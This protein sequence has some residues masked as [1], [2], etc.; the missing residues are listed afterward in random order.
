M[1]V[2]LGAVFVLFLAFTAKY[3]VS[4]PDEGYYYT[5][6]HRLLLGEKMIAD[7]W[8]L[9][10]LVHLFNLLPNILYIKLT[11]GTAGLILFMRYLFIAVDAAFYAYVYC[12]LRCFK[13]WGVAAA[14]LFCA[15]I[16][17]TLLTIAYFTAAPMATLAV[18]LMLVS[19]EK[20]KSAVKLVFAGIVMACGILAEP[21]LIAIFLMWFVLTAVREILKAKQK[22]F[23]E[24][25]A[26][27]LDKRIFTWT[28]L[29]AV[30][31]FIPYM[32]YLVL[33]GSFEGVGAAIPYLSS[34]EEYNGA[35]LIDFEKLW[36]A[37]N[38]YGIP[39]VLGGAVTLAAAGVLRIKKGLGPKRKQALLIAAFAF[40]A[41]GC[42][43]AA[44]TT[45][46]GKDPER[47]VAFLQYNNFTLLIFSPVLWL[48]CEK[49]TPRLFVLWL[50]GMLFSVL[51]DISSTVILASGGGLVRTACILQLPVLLGEL[52][53]PDAEK[54]KKAVRELREKAL[55]TAKSAVAVCVAAALL[56]NV[57]YILFEGVRK[58][59]EFL[60]SDAPLNS[61]IEKGPF[62]GLYTTAEIKGVYMDML[63]DLDGIV[64]EDRDRAPVC[65]LSLF[66]F[67][68]LYMGL[69][70]GAYSAWYEYD[71]PER[72]AAYWALRP[73]QQP[74]YIYVPYYD[75]F[76]FKRLADETVSEK[77]S[78]LDA[79]VQGERT[80]GKAGCIIRVTK[81]S[82][83]KTTENG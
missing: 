46:G 12:K 80:E 16:Q 83:P 48:L 5:V 7:E 27:L 51:V 72:L 35:N 71:E 58:P 3:G 15:V 21:F 33:S 68:Y 4:A 23:A 70:Y 59:W 78:G 62:C 30:A 18:W 38:F 28:T 6:A 17:Q 2:S 81:L 32:A 24:P 50:T 1:A 77:L 73:A 52:R 31:V 42:V 22:P 10:Q 25:Y 41:A 54:E 67:T 14:F 56:W 47:W 13:G 40:Y 8:N 19:D 53:G 43:F 75:M 34:G 63:E 39:F 74:A 65:V 11:G 76:S 45:F 66:P 55:R 69:P 57:C 49:K 37:V 64:A 82:L 9:A 44:V 36:S 79:F 20:E 60:F 61:E 29:G 26:F